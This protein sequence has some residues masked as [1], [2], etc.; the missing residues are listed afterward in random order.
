LTIARLVERTFGEGSFRALGSMDAAQDSAI[1]SLETLRRARARQSRN[2]VRA[3]EA[4]A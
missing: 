2:K 3:E 4:A 1:L